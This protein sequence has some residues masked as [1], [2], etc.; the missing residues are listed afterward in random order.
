MGAGAFSTQS[1]RSCRVASGFDQPGQ[2]D[3]S[4]AGRQWVAPA[5]LP[6]PDQFT[7]AQRASN[8]DV[9]TGGSRAWDKLCERSPSDKAFD[10][11]AQHRQGRSKAMVVADRS[12]RAPRQFR[13][14]VG[15]CELP[16]NSR[17]RRARE[18]VGS[19]H[20]FRF[21]VPNNPPDWASKNAVSC[22]ATSNAPRM[23]L[24]DIQRSVRLTGLHGYSRSGDCRR[25]NAARTPLHPICA[26]A[27]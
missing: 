23:G 7:N 25:P 27:A 8:R 20:P 15:F 21:R 24:A 1:F 16:D 4:D 2:G 14:S 5:G 10:R 22:E 17:S 9:S 11:E 26:V 3:G 6:L 19:G 13:L 18:A 12:N